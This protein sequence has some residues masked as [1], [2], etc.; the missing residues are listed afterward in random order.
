M[1]DREAQIT[2]DDLEKL[3]DAATWSGAQ[4]VGDEKIALDEIEWFPSGPVARAFVLDPAPVTLICG[5]WGSGKTTA[6]FVKLLLCACAVPPSPID[7]VRYARVAVVRDTYRNL[8]TNTIPSWQERF[9]KTL[10]KWKGGGGGE[11]G[12]HVIDFVL[13]DGT[14]LHLEVLFAAVGDHNVKQFC[15][16]LQ[17][18][19]CAMNGMDELP[20]DLIG[21]MMPRLGRW[22]PP[23]HRPPDW[24]KFVDY[25]CKIMADM[26]AP[27][28]DNHTVRDFSEKP[29]E[30]YKLFIQPSGLSPNAENIENLRDGYYDKLAAANEDWW[31]KRFIENKFGYSR[32]GKPVYPEFN[33]DLHVA[34]RPLKYEKKRKLVLGLDAQKD[35]CAVAQQREFGGRLNWLHAFIPPV[36][37]GAKQF[38]KWLADE[39]AIVYPDLGEYEFSLDPSGFDPNGIDDDFTWAEVFGRAF[40]LGDE[41]SAF[42]LPA[43]TNNLDPRIEVVR[44][45]LVQVDGFA[46]C[47]IGCKPLIRPF[48][49]GYRYGDSKT[50][51]DEVLTQ[52]PIKNE[53]SHVMEAGQYGALRIS[54][55]RNTIGRSPKRSRQPAEIQHDPLG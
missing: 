48:M 45:A 20:E 49:T 25:W 50:H 13:S 40:G 39:V 2:P 46:M 16:G 36:R 21:Y 23:Q 26:N 37:M 34:A 29:K 7:G 14:V 38:G 15:D 22:P 4:S 33:R 1:S 43:P 10:G 31:V 5:P 12:A 19:A 3:Q 47:P 27:E 41:W 52:I 11:P 42:V 55:M 8:E 30:G 28:E 53:W 32:K 17:I 24:K 35:A 54:G 9:P 51:G 6:L 18:T 44:T